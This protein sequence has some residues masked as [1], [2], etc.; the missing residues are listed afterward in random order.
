MWFSSV[1]SHGEE[2]GALRAGTNLEI[3]GTLVRAGTLVPLKRNTRS[4]GHPDLL[5]PR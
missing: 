4:D 1:A 5:G 2:R 3:A